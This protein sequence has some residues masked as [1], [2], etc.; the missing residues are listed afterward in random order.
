FVS[1]CPLVKMANTYPRFTGVFLGTDY[2]PESRILHTLEGEASYVK[3]CAIILVMVHAVST[4]EIRVPEL[5]Q[6]S[7]TI[8]LLVKLFQCH[9]YKLWSSFIQICVIFHIYI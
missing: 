5:Q 8:H 2:L 6:L 1:V 3:R 7:L 9:I 4:A